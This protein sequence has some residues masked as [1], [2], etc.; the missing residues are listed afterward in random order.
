M[1]ALPP[2]PQTLRIAYDWTIDEDMKAV[3]REYYRYSG[4]GASAAGLATLAGN[5]HSSYVTNLAPLFH[6]SRVLNSVQIT[7]LTSA[8]APEGGATG[9]APGTRAGTK[10]PASAAV[11]QSQEISR[12]YRGGHPRTYWPM[13]V[14]DDMFDSQTWKN[15]FCRV[16]VQN[17]L[18]AHFTDWSTDLVPG[19][20]FVENVNISYYEGFTV[21][22]GT[23]GRARNVSTPRLAPLV[24]VVQGFIIRLAIAQIRKRLLASG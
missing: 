9:D 23:T 14:E 21:H 13:G 11:L 20:D 24:D 8:T 7:D 15:N 19:I 12:R 22:T 1:P 5:I 6:S 4:P 10:L 17:G 3:C 2:V 18:N 16:E